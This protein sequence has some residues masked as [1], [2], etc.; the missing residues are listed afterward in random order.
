MSSITLASAGGTQSI[1]ATPSTSTLAV[2]GLNGNQVAFGSPDPNEVVLYRNQYQNVS[3]I[4]TVVSDTID[5]NNN[6]IKAI[7]FP[8][9]LVDPSGMHST[10]TNNDRITIL[11]P[12]YY[13]LNMNG[14]WEP[15]TLSTGVLLS[16]FSRFDSS[17]SLTGNFGPV[18]KKNVPS[19]LLRYNNSRVIFLDVGD[20][21]RCLC[22]NLSGQTRYISSGS[23]LTVCKLGEA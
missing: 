20:Y 18:T 1:V 12:G 10:T 21:V 16:F 4:C 11:E 23:S 13:L 2:K 15:G 14:S 17:A 19:H 7:P 9:S 6:A 8:T 22:Q 3:S 5:I